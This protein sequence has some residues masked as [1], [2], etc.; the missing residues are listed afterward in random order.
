MQKAAGLVALF[1]LHT[2]AH[3]AILVELMRRELKIAKVR[4]TEVT[5]QVSLQ[6][7]KQ[8]NRIRKRT[9]G[10]VNWQLKNEP[11]SIANLIKN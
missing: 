3:A 7:L 8:Q 4:W 9:E 11:C 10:D 5:H 6:S 2:M 1:R